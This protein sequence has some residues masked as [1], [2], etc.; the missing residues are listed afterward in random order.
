MV[1]LRLSA[2]PTRQLLVLPSLVVMLVL[3]SISWPCLLFADALAGFDDD[4]DGFPQV[5]S[6][7]NNV[8]VSAPPAAAS[9]GFAPTYVSQQSSHSSHEQ[10]GSSQA[11]SSAQPAPAAAVAQDSQAKGL[12]SLQFDPL[13]RRKKAKPAANGEASAAG[14]SDAARPALTPQVQQLQEDLAKL[15]SEWSQAMHPEA[16][17]DDSA[18][19][20]QAAAAAC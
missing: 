15:V 8:P 2:A 18:A 10:A 1:T 3:A 4:D 13:R 20:A 9:I 17:L 14:S 5:N 11:S 12:P 19:A 7:V 6:T 16:D